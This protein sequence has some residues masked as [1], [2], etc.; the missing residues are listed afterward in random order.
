M[1][2]I[3]AYE[4][5]VRIRI[6]EEAVEQLFL[7]GE[8][9]GTAHTAIGQEAI[10]VGVCAA[11]RTQ[12]RITSTHRGHA[13]LLARGGEPKRM[14]AELF[15]RAPGYSGGRGGSQMMADRS[16]GFLG[17]NGITGGSLPIAVG[18]ALAARMTGREA[19]TVCFFGDGASNQGTFHESMN[20]AALWKLPVLFVCENNGYAMSTP[21]ACA[22]A[23]GGKVALRAA[24]YG[25]P[26]IEVDGNWFP[27]V[28]EAA[29]D[30]RTR[31]VAGEGP[32]LLECRTYRLSGHSR[33]D[34]RV[35]RSREEEAAARRREPLVRTE[36]HLRENHLL[37]EPGQARLRERIGQRIREAIEFA[38]QAPAPDLQERSRNRCA[39]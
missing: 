27:A 23:G 22:V 3:E 24:G 25:M 1:D 38:R 20:L 28:H 9:S 30:A 36:A 21:T 14:M 8:I 19:M 29:R 13:H 17:G 35:Y 12:D 26:A 32:T 2:W 15:G 34:P 11:L 39:P 4:Q 33:G 37:D 31:A 16:I 5:M 6:F 10:A 7:E 18:A